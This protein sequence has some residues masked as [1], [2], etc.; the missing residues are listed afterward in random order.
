M[1]GSES[2]FFILMT[3]TKIEISDVNIIPIT[4]Q[5]G[6]VGFSSIRLFGF[7]RLNSIGLKINEDGSLKITTPAKKLP[8]GYL[9]YYELPLDVREEIRLA[10]EEKIKELG[11]FENMFTFKTPKENEEK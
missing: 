7:L 10:I 4:P 9:M 8:T 1:S 2:V 11:L 3:K 5:A 6:L